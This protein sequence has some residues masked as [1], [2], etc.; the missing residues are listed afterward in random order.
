MAKQI[1]A[2]VEAQIL[3][4]ASRGY[5]QEEIADRLGISTRSVQRHSR[6]YRTVTGQTRRNTNGW[7]E[8]DLDYAKELLEDGASYRDVAETTGISKTTLRTRFPGLG[9]SFEDTARLATTLPKLPE[10]LRWSLTRK[11]IQS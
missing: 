6:K 5:T 9:F 11:G 4:F 1:D 3:I 2:N 7:S 10:D 8:D